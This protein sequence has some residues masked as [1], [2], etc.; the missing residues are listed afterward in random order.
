MSDILFQSTF[1]KNKKEE[2]ERL[3]NEYLANGGTIDRS[4]PRKSSSNNNRKN[5]NI[6]QKILYDFSD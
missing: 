2:D 3:I 5:K 6:N 4:P 1:L